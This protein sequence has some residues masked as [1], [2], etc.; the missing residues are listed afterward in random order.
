MPFLPAQRAAD[1][2]K[3]LAFRAGPNVDI[4]GVTGSIPVA[5]TIHPTDFTSL[6]SGLT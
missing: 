1:A 3:F 2:A 6:S 4:V 5:P